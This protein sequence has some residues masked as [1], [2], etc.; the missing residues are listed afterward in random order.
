MNKATRLIVSARQKPV[1]QLPEWALC[2]DYTRKA[3]AAE[4]QLRRIVKVEAGSTFMAEVECHH[5]HRITQN[6]KY[7]RTVGDGRQTAIAVDLHDF[8][9]GESC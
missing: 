1:E 3:H 9:E 8:D 5:C 2:C 4:E 7:T 6:V